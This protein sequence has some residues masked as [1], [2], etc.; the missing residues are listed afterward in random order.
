MILNLKH[1][2][3]HVAY[4]KFKMDHIDKVIQL[5]QE[6]DWMSSLDLTSAYGHLWIQEKYQ[7]FFQFTWRGQ[8]Y[9]YITL[10]QG[11]SDSPRMFVRCTNPI[12]AFLRKQLIDIVIYIDDTF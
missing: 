10:P 1:L 9:C 3:K 2:N 6:G 7:K 4:T 5:I 12:M 8:Y 11:F